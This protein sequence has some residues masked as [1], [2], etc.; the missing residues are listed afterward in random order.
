MQPCYKN[1][2]DSNSVFPVAEKIYNTG[3]SLPSSYIL[4]DDEQKKVVEKIKEFYA[5]RN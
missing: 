3:I 5:H 2:L 4:T 1:I